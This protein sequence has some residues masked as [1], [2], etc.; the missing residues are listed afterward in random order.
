MEEVKN[1]K[2]HT[3]KIRQP[4]GS[5]AKAIIFCDADGFVSGVSNL[6]LLVDWSQRR[7][8]PAIDTQAPLVITDEVKH[9]MRFFSDHT[10]CWFPGC[11]KLRESYKAELAKM[12]ANGDCKGCEKGALI[13][14]YIQLVGLAQKRR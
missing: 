14:K 4:D 12:E 7:N 9:N 6:G 5:T 8:T 11:E 2:S 3:F 10:P 1:I 13:R